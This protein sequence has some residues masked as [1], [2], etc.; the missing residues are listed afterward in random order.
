M[1][2]VASMWLQRAEQLADVGAEL[3]TA[4]GA[5]GF[6]G[7]AARRLGELSGILGRESVEIARALQ[8]LA[9]ALRADADTVDAMNT[10]ALRLA[11][12]AE[13][14]AAAETAPVDLP[15]AAS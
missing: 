5:S 3:A 7:P 14:E 15:E 2:G 4:I 6:E 8:E 9:F 11:Q 13:L 10:D 12:Q 1:R